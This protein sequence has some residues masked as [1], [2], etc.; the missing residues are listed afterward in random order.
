MKHSRFLG[1]LLLGALSLLDVAGQQ[2]PLALDPAKARDNYQ[3]RRGVPISD[4]INVPPGSD[5]RAPGPVPGPLGTLDQ[6][7]S[8]LSLGGTVTE[9][10]GST[11]AA[12]QPVLIGLRTRVGT[13]FF[14]E[15]FSYLFGE[16][17][18]P[19][20]TDEYG[21]SLNVANGS[22]PPTSPSIYWLP[23]PHTTN[24]HAGGA[25]YWSPHAEK[26]YATQAGFVSVKWRKAQPSTPVGSPPGV[27]T[28]TN[29]S[30]IYT[31]LT[32][33]SV[34]SATSVKP[35]RRMY[36][37]EGPFAQIGRPINI[38]T[39]RIK[40]IKIVYNDQFPQFTPLMSV[41]TNLVRR[42]FPFDGTQS[43]PLA[44]TNSLWY[45]RTLNSI[46]AYNF[47][48]KR[49]FVEFL[50]DK[51]GQANGQ[52]IHQQ[53]GFEIVEVQQRPSAVD[54]TT[55][56]GEV[57]T[58]Y[59]G[60]SPGDAPELFADPILNVG[61]EYVYR[62]SLAGTTEFQYFA[63]RETQNQDDYQM[64][65]MEEGLQGLRWPYRYVRYQMIWPADVAKYS[66]YVRPPANTEQ[67]ARSTAVALPSQNAPQIAY[68]DPLDQPRGKLT[69]NFAYYSWLTPQYPAHRALL[70]F[71][72]G[73]YVRFER[74][75]SWLDEAL[76][77][78]V[79][80]S[81]VANDDVLVGGLALANSVASQLP[82]LLE[83]PGFAVRNIRGTEGV[84]SLAMAD[85]VLATPSLQGSVFTSIVPVINFLNGGGAGNFADDTAFPGLSLSGNEDNFVTEAT[86]T[87]TIPQGGNWTFGVSSDD[88][89]RCDIGTNSF[90]FPSTRGATDTFAT[91][92]LGAGEYPVRLVY[93]ECA[94]GAEV[95]F[96]AAPGTNST[97]NANFKLVGDTAGGGLA[98]RS[99][100][101]LPPISSR[102]RVVHATAF[103]GQRIGAPAGE[104]GSGLDTNY[105]AGYIQSSQ[106]DSYHPGA[107]VDP[108]VSGFELANQ[109]AI[110]PVNA[111]P[112]KNRIEVWW[113]RKNAVDLT[114][115]FKNTLWPSVIARYT[116]AWPTDAS[117]II[118][119]S[120]DGSGALPSL[121]ARGTI[122][123]QND[124]TLP[125]YN[126]NEEH[127]LMQGGQ[128][129]ALRDDLNI[130]AAGPAY[131]SDPFVLLEY[132][133]SDG[134]LAIRPFKVRR[135]KPEAGITFAYQKRAAQILQ[136]PM[137]L[138]LLGVAFAP[139]IPGVP[140]KSLNEELIA[141]EVSDSTASNGFWTLTTESKHGFLPYQT[142]ALQD[143]Q[144]SITRWFFATNVGESTVEGAISTNRPFALSPDPLG[145]GAT[146]TA[147]VNRWRFGFTNATQVPLGPAL[148]ALPESGTNW[149]VTVTSRLVSGGYVEVD[150]GF[151]RP[152]EATNGANVV[153]VP[154]INGYAD[155]AF[156]DWVLAWNEQPQ[157]SFATEIRTLR[158]RYKSAT[159][160]DRKGNVW[161]YRGP[162]SPDRPE[163]F[164]MRFFYNT[165]PGFFFPTLALGDQ[166]PVGT[167]TPYLRRL[168]SN[169]RY[170][171][172]AVYGNRDANQENDK[173]ALPI[174]YH[175]Y[176]PDD[177]PV[178]QMAE[179]LTT[180]KRGLPAVRG[181]TSL[182]VLYQQSQVVMENGK[183]AIMPEKISAVLHD[184]TREKRVEFDQANVPAS[185]RTETSRGKIWFPNL[186]PH[187]VKRFWLDPN[188]GT[189]GMLVFAGE[190]VDAPLGDKYVLLNVAGTQDATTLREL[191]RADL[192]DPIEKGEWD[193]AINALATDLEL[194][195][196]NPAVPGTYIPHPVEPPTTIGLGELAAITDDDV[197]RDSYALTAIGPD[198]GYITLI[199]GNGLLTPE[200]EPVSME[201]IRVVP[202]LYRGEVNVIESENPLNERLT[203]QQV[204]DLAGHAE[205]YTFEWR[206]TAPVDGQP[207]EIYSRSHW[208][209]PPPAWSHVRFPLGTDRVASI[210]GIADHRVVNDVSDSIVP[211][212][213]IPF[214]AV[215]NEQGFYRFT[216]TTTGHRLAKGN[217]LVMSSA[218]DVQVRVTVHELPAAAPA[219]VVVSVD[220]NQTARLDAGQIF[221]LA[222][223]VLQ[224]QPQS[225]AF[226]SFEV[227]PAQDNLTELWL[228]LTLA[229]G[230][231]A[232][233]YLNGG[234]VVR[235]GFAG[236]DTNT[237]PENPP[238]LLANPRLARSFRVPISA[239]AGAIEGVD[240]FLTN[241]LA[242]ELFAPAVPGAALDFQVRVE[243]IK[244][245][246]QVV[247]GSIWI[248]LD[249]SQYEDGV[250]A[251]VGGTADVR[252]L[253]DN[254]LTMRYRPKA[255]ANG[256]SQWTE[257]QLAEGWIK[258]VLKGIN[259][260]NQRITD[261]YNNAVNTD[262]SVISQ[263]GARWEGNIALNLESM[264]NYGLIEI[265][266]TVLN[267]GK[268]LSINADINYGPANDALL[269]AAGYINDLYML[270]GNEAAADAANPTIG[271]GTADRTY[272]DIAT[273]LFAFKG[274]LPTLLAEELSLLRGRDDFLVPGV[275]TRPVYNRMVWNY[276]RGIDAGEVI[277]ALNYN[278]LDQNTDG[279][280]DALDALKLYPQGHGDAY[281]HYLTALKG[282]Y[283]LLLDPNFDWV[284]RSEAV[285]VL[286]RPVSVDYQDER[287]FAAAAGAVARTGR[288]IFDLTWRQDFRSGTAL[289]WEHLRPTRT[290]NKGRTR[291][292][293]VD[294]WAARTGLG[295]YVN[296]VAGNAFLPFQDPD[297]A[298]N[299]SI[300]QVDRTTVPELQE[301]PS[302][303][304]SLQTAMDNAESGL[305]PLGL[306]EDAVPFDLNPNGVVAGEGNTH[307][308]QVYS[309]AKGALQNAVIA[310]DDAKDVTRLMRSEQDSLADLR[311]AVDKQELAYTNA[312]IE[313]FGTPYPEDIG[314]GKTYRTG[315]AG[316]DLIH[317][318]YVDNA[319]INFNGL[320]DPAADVTWRI[321]TQTFTADWL[322]PNGISDLNFIQPA[323]NGPVDGTLA[324]EEWLANRSLY[325]EYNLAAH[326]FFKKPAS[327]VG[328]RASPGKIQQ[329]I[330]DI[331]KARNAA[332]EAFYWADAAKYDSDW[333]IQ[334]LKRK[335][336]SHK[337]IYALEGSLLKARTAM[338]SARLAWELADL[339]FE[340]ASKE[341]AETAEIVVESL[342]KSFVSG[343]AIGGDLTSPV[344]A[345]KEAS[346]AVAVTA[347]L[348]IRFAATAI[349][350]SLE[351]ATETAAEWTEYSQIHP[352][353]WN[354][355]LRD[356]MGELRDKLYGMNN[357]FMTINARLQELDD[358]KRKYRT[359]V[360][361]GDRIQ[362]ERE[363]FRQRT[364]AIIQGYR[365]RDAAFRI[366][367]NEKLE[368]YKSLFDLAAQYSFMAAK[369]YDYETGLLGTDR[370]REFINRIVNARALGVVKNGQ[371]QF[372]GSNNGDPGLSSVLAE[373]AGDWSVVRS[374]LGFNNPDAYG[375]TASL[376]YENFRIITNEVRW[377]EVMNLARKANL[378]DDPDVRRH[379][380]QIDD[381]SGLPVP[382][383]VFEFGTAIGNG[384]NLFG[385]PLSPGDHKFTASS[386]ATKIFAAGVALEGYVGMDDPA[387]N[388]GAVAGGGGQ[389][390]QDPSLI[391]LDPSALSANPYVYLIPVG[392][393]SMRSPPLGDTSD[394]RTW[395]VNDVAIPLPFNI[396]GSDYSSTRLW[397]SEDSLTEQPFTVRKH[398]AFRPVST[399]SLFSPD[400]YTGTGGLQRS[401]WTST[402]LIGRSVWNSKWKIVIPGRE[403]LSD[404]NEGI[405]RFLRT[406]KDVKLHF[407]TYSYSGN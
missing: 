330:S 390:P 373:M 80:D 33:Q 273:A 67:E 130:T 122:Y 157:S 275:E 339:G 294:H 387:A 119:A 259:P 46:R 313:L 177:A 167:A 278:I 179:T 343:L 201:V 366:F 149:P 335:I 327:W 304:E 295:A 100:N 266:E 347:L 85:A 312:L 184:P 300:Q 150:F 146:N 405:E 65:W 58:P 110:I 151:P 286:G 363:I 272:G 95:E 4:T 370:G 290:S 172:H 239:L 280:A 375:T 92:N 17:I 96:F 257:P 45:D 307:F 144:G 22:R 104:L 25:Y 346:E 281:G 289:G 43:G 189:N 348:R 62:H 282:Y 207:P 90:S 291:N 56:L 269:L 288:Q 351:Y 263:A 206:I 203:L 178:L 261:L 372:A 14:G 223:R 175:P 112:G 311:A 94:I 331:A 332:F 180:P 314:P 384:L 389:S 77:G 218:E 69:E 214:T 60:V 29:D 213:S 7:Q 31:L 47:A 161:V 333:A 240:G 89:F 326:G 217:R 176:W 199:A 23:E 192:S 84:C 182:E 51:R 12:N 215:T 88:G 394:V 102:P 135:E 75:F 105:L 396:G 68:Q 186:P 233:L 114:R 256:W 242:V 106:G 26:V 367:R 320:L 13:P 193:A 169:G 249:A 404:P 368:R 340:N 50:G 399:A 124:A 30:R 173:N 133:E 407:V 237:V 397:Q 252:S 355:E 38:P 262:V 305:T 3:S 212:S 329:A 356:A 323:R 81:P 11:N 159:V 234:L 318:M 64:H 245:I 147:L 208:I 354:Q 118:L 61:Q 98:V 108:F 59:Q 123:V 341:V 185:I 162:H 243:A 27:S 54:V 156:N 87:I 232:K 350:K 359:L 121:E 225:I 344:R 181:Q 247:A 296:W 165:L 71:S 364:A 1:T 101:F 248:P 82:W 369:A 91:F 187:L 298:H 274:Q 204:V 34:I 316:P 16:I 138:P 325:V 49:V 374:R 195:V 8:L 163:T 139:K 24:G 402:R 292:W 338:E 41:G 166:P 378:L 113:F 393:D 277:Y 271:I 392:T 241:R 53:L 52:D 164:T 293:G 345:A 403:L 380:L 145:A 132:T 72:S 238:G 324:L 400:I 73:E 220:P 63:V 386:F 371:P 10:T 236:A 322:E 155:G 32:R 401:Q 196:E 134:K 279:K 285:T 15:S 148:L 158:E 319:E 209:A 109:G 358:A 36:W 44:I 152:S 315:F 197:A 244:S 57:L 299:N 66:H 362:A 79:G 142:F 37:T 321:D 200:G 211:V 194:F 2:P 116:T 128:A 93:F 406:V 246:D 131:S 83:N 127:A 253:S 222:E 78:S 309:R 205:D 267:R 99:R 306:P 381:G 310:F 342:P 136:P 391:F 129:W 230:L 283:H 125:G 385:H 126:P 276:T 268:D 395:N 202:N 379:C 365:T 264:N 287:K 143:G 28:V 383:L 70:Q 210:E 297:P 141:W 76:R 337:Y 42:E 170:V 317:Y 265:Y 18:P 107:Y 20:D 111:I 115:G 35:S 284:P 190:F 219:E 183:P 361:E 377:K 154:V 97:F 398:Q 120:N 117:E 301:L 258:R 336:D 19:P 228:S 251:I 388:S 255:N 357:R 198:T 227:N 224:G 270:V 221:G 328:R 360:A 86:G 174:T 303:V 39:D 40:D 55:E 250:R 382:G 216:L 254:Y 235:T 229:E 137:P 153:L 302:L 260:F 376:R 5:G 160:T 103:V 168:D 352:E 21:V 353:E 191:C 188:A 48:D 334:S 74:V 349:Q 140:R 226:S 9:R 6:F 231:G 171:G 308:E